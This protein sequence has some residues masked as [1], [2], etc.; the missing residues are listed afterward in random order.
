MLFSNSGPHPQQSDMI[1]DYCLLS[2]YQELC[3]IVGGAVPNGRQKKNTS[4]RPNRGI[5][6]N[7]FKSKTKQHQ[8]WS[9][10]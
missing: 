6:Q 9:S 2:A 10:F 1:Q 4:I 8:S 7:N 5:F 3:P